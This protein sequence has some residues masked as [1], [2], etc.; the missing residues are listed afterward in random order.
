[1]RAVGY[2]SQHLHQALPITRSYGIMLS[3]PS[4]IAVCI[5]PRVKGR[6]QNNIH[7]RV[8][9]ILTSTPLSHTAPIVPNTFGW[10][11][12]T[13]LGKRRVRTWQVSLSGKNR[14]LKRVKNT[15]TKKIPSD[16]PLTVSALVSVNTNDAF[17]GVD[18]L[19]LSYTSSSKIYPPALDAGEI[20]R[21]MFVL[22]VRI[23]CSTVSKHPP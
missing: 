7:V 5:R 19:P 6:R 3:P 17:V 2:S 4:G 9:I 15:K 23:E 8:N 11:S 21:D 22:I 16:V 14:V 12:H 18:S 1:M 13:F 10:L 20:S